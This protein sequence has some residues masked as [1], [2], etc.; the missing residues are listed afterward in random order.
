[1]PKRLDKRLRLYAVT[2]DIADTA[3]LV[4]QVERAIRGGTS[5]VQYRN[6][7]ADAC[8]RREQAQALLQL[9]REQQVPLLIN[10]YLDLALELDADGVH[11]GGDDG[12]L[13]TA[14]L[15]LGPDKWLGA[16]C[17]GDVQLAQHALAAGATYVA[18][19]ALFPSGSKPQARPAELDVLQQ[20]S[21]LPCPVCGIGG[22]DASNAAQATAA[23]ARWLAVIG[24]LFNAG[25]VEDNA[26]RILRAMHQGAA[27]VGA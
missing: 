3:R 26:R 25:D 5:I 8:L 21:R 20:A 27:M 18:F 1:M 13:A 4:Q 11:L 24:G 15:S 6:K 14:R 16:S 19:G 22:I 9:C 7:R 10:D 12:D 23:G 17:Y 2:P